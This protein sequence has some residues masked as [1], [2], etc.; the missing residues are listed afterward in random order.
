MIKERY[1]PI[2]AAIAV[3]LAF[4]AAIMF[5]ALS[6][7][8]AVPVLSTPSYVTEVFD[9]ESVISIDI[10]VDEAEWA[11]MLENAINE[12]YIS[13]DLT[14][15]D[16]KYS[17]VGIRPKGNTSLS[18]VA[19][20]STTDRYSFR[21]NLSEY[22]DGQTLEG[23]DDVV[24]NNM[25]SDPSYMKE[26]LTYELMAEMG[27]NTPAYAFANITVN[28]EA[29][30]LYL[31]IEVIDEDFLQR[32]YG[33]AYGT[34]YKPESDGERGAGAGGT[35]NTDRPNH[36]AFGG[37]PPSAVPEG[38][39]VQPPSPP[40][41]DASSVSPQA[42][43]SKGS[44]GGMGG[45]SSGGTSLVYTDDEYT[46]YENIF[47]NVVTKGLTTQDKQEVIDMIKALSTGENLESCLDIDEVLRY[48]AVNTFLVNLDSYAGP[49][50]HNYYLYEEDGVFQILPWDFNLSFGAFQMSDASKIINFPIDEPVTD[51]MENSPLISTLLSIDEYKQI[52]HSYLQQIIDNYF[53][54]G[55][56]EAA[57]NRLDT[58][59]ADYVKNDAT[60]F[61]TYDE[62]TSCVEQLHIFGADRAEAVQQQLTGE[63]P[64]N[65]YGTLETTLNAQSMG[66]MGGGQNKNRP[67]E[68][69]EES[70]AS[71]SAAN[72]ESPQSD[73]NNVDLEGAFQQQT[74]KK[75][76]DNTNSNIQ[77]SIDTKGADADVQPPD[78]TAEH[79]AD[80]L[81]D[82]AKV[83]IREIMSIIRNAGDRDLTDDELSQL[84][85]LG[86]DE[87]TIESIKNRSGMERQTEAFQGDAYSTS[88]MPHQ[89]GLMLLY[90]SLAIAGIF[91]I[92]I[93]KT[94][95]F[96]SK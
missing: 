41:D 80:V 95:K 68:N 2:I 44:A 71:T 55:A 39:A 34:L 83:N 65:S 15:N 64:A 5:Y 23:L 87:Q 60:A 59:I 56:Y 46:S 3:I 38:E 31:A 58:L 78:I 81:T 25:I 33:D 62:Y 42:D 96:T 77:S 73:E 32:Y 45:M 47:N 61:Y 36:P 7:S 22:I 74:G 6:F 66:Q 9:K 69:Q 82:T 16:V 18:H 79:N 57:I 4:A 70:T 75:G 76:N 84:S 28:G 8:D 67:V 14:V 49:I 52:Y 93:F 89:V 20:N 53:T 48:F 27:V 51:S 11:D 37:S 30:G 90:L 50:K 54:S 12:E 85:E 86:A 94:K 91:F 43:R 63:Q 88:I 21:L 19:S 72:Q 24:L 26:Y 29:W 40:Q 92:Y 1:M 10:S 13:C 35:K 17:T